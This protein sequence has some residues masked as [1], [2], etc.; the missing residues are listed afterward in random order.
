MTFF[1]KPPYHDR[2]NFGTVLSSYVNVNLLYK[3]INE[4]LLDHIE[5]TASEIDLRT[6]KRYIL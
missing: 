2:N 3:K 1:L 4:G 5:Y 6:K